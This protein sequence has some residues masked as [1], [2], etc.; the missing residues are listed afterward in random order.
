[1][2]ITLYRLGGA[3]VSMHHQILYSVGSNVD[4]VKP[5][6]IKLEVAACSLRTQHWGVRMVDSKSG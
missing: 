5:K 1:L 6:T 3:M 2:I 4:Q